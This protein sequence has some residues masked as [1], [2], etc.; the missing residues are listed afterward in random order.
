[1]KEYYEENPDKLCDYNKLILQQMKRV[2]ELYNTHPFKSNS[3]IDILYYAITKLLLKE[4][5]D[6]LK[7]DSIY[8]DDLQKT[9]DALDTETTSK[10]NI[11]DKISRFLQGIKM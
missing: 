1:M 7:L 6:Q 10:L 2:D 11:F 3:A 5:H 8:S 9:S 4:L